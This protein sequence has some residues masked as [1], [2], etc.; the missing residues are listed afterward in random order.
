MRKP[1]LAGR[2]GEKPGYAPGRTWR[3]FASCGASEA[4]RRGAM[5][6]RSDADG[7]GS[8]QTRRG[9]RPARSGSR[10]APARMARDAAS[11]RAS[12]MDGAG[13]AGRGTG[14]SEERQAAP[15][16]VL[17]SAKRGKTPRR[18]PRATFEDETSCA[19]LRPEDILA[20][21]ERSHG[22]ANRPPSKASTV[23]RNLA[24]P[25]K[26]R[27]HATKARDRISERQGTARKQATR[28]ARLPRPRPH[29]G[30][31]RHHAQ[32]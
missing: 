17:E 25:R 19:G 29:L 5:S 31:A 6:E 30:K 28:R 15:P 16:S 18:Q 4:G 12:A 22:R 2:C 10:R 11:R 20:Y 3:A 32:S 27:A 24:A 9:A 21:V 23:A 8:R 13:G 26:G 7:N 14:A 1:R